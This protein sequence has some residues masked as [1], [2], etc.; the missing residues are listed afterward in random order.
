MYNPIQYH[1]LLSKEFPEK[2]K[3]TETA[4]PELADILICMWE[5]EYYIKDTNPISDIIIVDGCVNLVVSVE[6]KSIVWGLCSK[7][8]FDCKPPTHEKYIGF[9]FYP[10]AFYALTGIDT[11]M[12]TDNMTSID[13]VDSSFHTAGFFELDYAHMKDYLIGYIASLSKNKKSTEYIQ[14]FN[15][16]NDSNFLNTKMLYESICLS[17]RQI[18]RLFK[19]HYG[20]KPQMILSIIKFQH[21][22]T[23]LL[24]GRTEIDNL[25]DNYYDQSKFINEFKKNIGLT[26]VQFINL[27]K[28]RKMSF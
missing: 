2:I 10:G 4:I 23:E 18:Q 26:P 9:R 6:D 19:K 28:E 11:T 25:I 27:C 8:I 24:Y 17:P 14:L 22:A 3:Y 1:T 7:T 15:G 12:I 20:L 5:S 13:E 21:C 16:I